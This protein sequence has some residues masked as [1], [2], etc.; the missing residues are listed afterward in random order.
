MLKKYESDNN[1]T[2]RYA[3]SNIYADY[4]DDAQF[5]FMKSALEKASG[6]GKFGLIQAMG[7]YL[8]RCT[9]DKIDE[10]V[11]LLASTVQNSSSK[12]MNMQTSSTLGRV[13]KF[14]DGKAKE[15]ENKPEAE[16]YKKISAYITEQ[17]AEIKKKE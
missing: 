16:Q 7:K 3:L 15:F 17:I 1:N 10:G 6:F 12:F 8:E 9:P 5:D 4:G 14:V 2:L 11:K 13:R